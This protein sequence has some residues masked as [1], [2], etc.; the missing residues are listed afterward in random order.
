MYQL[1]FV[2]L[3]VILLAIGKGGGADEDSSEVATTTSKASTTSDGDLNAET[4]GRERQGCCSEIYLGD[5]E[6]LLKC[7]T[8][9][10]TKLPAEGDQ[11]MAKTMRFLSCFV[12]CLYKQ[13]KY[14]GKNDSINMKMV[15]LDAENLYKDYPKE[16]KYHIEMMDFCRKDAV[17]L[18]NLL[19]AS[20][21]SA[22]LLKGACRPYLMMVF[23]CQSNYHEKHGCPYFRWE[24]NDKEKT[25][26]VCQES[27][28][29]CYKIDGLVP[30]KKSIL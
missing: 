19:K 2:L 13:K 1:K 29:K 20:P 6:H 4:C 18:Y 30:P 27:K 23:L 10:S 7:F 5:E 8:I 11:D 21:G 17:T 3:L 14:I 15:K 9:H 22:A 16:K 26:K 28:D 12:E 24:G 25:T